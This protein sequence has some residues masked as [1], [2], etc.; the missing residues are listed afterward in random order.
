MKQFL[1]LFLF[2]YPLFA[3]DKNAFASVQSA[4]A[5]YQFDNARIQL[6]GLEDS[7]K[8]SAQFFEYSAKVYRATGEFPK[9]RDAY[10]MWWRSD[11]NSV[12]ALASWAQLET[13]VQN[14]AKASELYLEL[15]MLDSLNPHFYKSLA[16][17]EIKRES[18]VGAMI[19]FDRALE[20]APKDQEVIAQMVRIY[21]ELKNYPKADSLIKS[22]LLED[23]QNLLFSKLNLRSAYSQKSYARVVEIG[24]RLLTEDEDS[25]RVTMRMVGIARYHLE[26]WKNAEILLLK[27]LGLSEDKEQL[28]YYVG[29]CKIAQGQLQE[30]QEY[31]R[32][33]IEAGISES[34]PLYQLN[35]ALSLD[36][37][38]RYGEAIPYYKAVW[39]ETQSPLILYYLARDYDEYY[40]D[41]KP[42]LEHYQ[43][44]LDEAGDEHYQY[45]DY[46]RKR[47]AELRKLLHFRQD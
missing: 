7:L 3:Q 37:Q 12:Q 14:Y 41:K 6:D 1:I 45:Q 27:T 13:V 44:F 36:E 46:S 16:Y 25:S 9:A 30:G 33:A 29:M 34:I 5:N 22:V 19:A 31:L 11:S 18:K 40:L 43:L 39:E 47:I 10:Q 38:R 4:L 35:L 28:L 26:D 24:N 42:A 17:L 8:N 15:I 2:T 23:P 32:M 21:I 20:L